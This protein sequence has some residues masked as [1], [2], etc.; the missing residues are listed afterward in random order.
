[1]EWKKGFAPV[2][3]KQS[4]VL[5]LGSFPSVKSREQGFYYGHKQNR[6]WKML[7]RFFNQTV[8]ETVQERKEFLIKNKV[9]LWDVIEKS[10]ID[11]SSDADITEQNSVPVDFSLVLNR[12]YNIKLIICNGKKAYQIFLKFNPNCAVPSVVLPST[13]PANGRYDE[14]L[15]MEQL[16]NIF[17]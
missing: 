8:P 5:I 12:Y 16:K 11:G 13:S 3:D 6:F 1:M 9:A 10:C 15:W 7:A 2:I 14:S 17:S 4:K